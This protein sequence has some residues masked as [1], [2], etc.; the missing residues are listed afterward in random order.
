MLLFQIQR[1]M[2]RR[3]MPIFILLTE[4]AVCSDI[5]V[6][7]ASIKINLGKT[8]CAVVVAK[9]NDTYAYSLEDNYSILIRRL[10]Y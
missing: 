8:F 3:K 4:A 2:K 6:I 1:T 10:K 5:R 9:P 7:A